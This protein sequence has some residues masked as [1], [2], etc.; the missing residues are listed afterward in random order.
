MTPDD[1]QRIE[2]WGQKRKEE[3][4]AVE[5]RV[6]TI[7]PACSRERETRDTHGN[8]GELELG[9]TG[10]DC[11]VAVSE[12]TSGENASIIVQSNKYGYIDRILFT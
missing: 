1:S 6:S 4:A 5:Q 8:T 10:A 12:P 11:R 9:T 7:V 3:L 2:P